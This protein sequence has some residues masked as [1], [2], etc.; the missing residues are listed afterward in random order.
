MIGRMLLFSALLAAVVT[1]SP[2]HP[3][4]PTPATID[5]VTAGVMYGPDAFLGS[6][7]PGAAAVLHDS[8]GAGSRIFPK[9]PALFDPAR[10]HPQY[11][12]AQ[13]AASRAAGIARLHYAAPLALA[14]AGRLACPATAP[15]PLPSV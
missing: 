5:E 15:P 10:G 13:A 12:T 11:P 14:R 8:F 1:G 9:R 7:G 6:T 3:Q 2:V 4:P